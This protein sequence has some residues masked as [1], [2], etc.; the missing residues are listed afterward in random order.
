[1]LRQVY[2]VKDTKSLVYGPPFMAHT[3]GEAER[4]IKETLSRGESTLSKYPED[5]DLYFLGQWDDTSGKYEFHDSPQ[6]MCK[7]VQ[8][9]EPKQ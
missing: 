4:V 9:V 3:H 2:T 5:F 7:V 1:M 8:L 6:H